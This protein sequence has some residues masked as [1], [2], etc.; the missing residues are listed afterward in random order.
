MISP[1][2]DVT[3][4]SDLPPLIGIVGPT[5]VGKSE[6]AVRLAD[7]LPVEIVSADSR[8]VYRGLDIGTAKPSPEERQRVP[9]H[10]IDL[11]DPEDDFSV[12]EFQD[13][14]YA[15]IDAILERGH[16]PLLVGGTGLYIRAV[17]EGVRFPRV[18]PDPALRQELEHRARQDGAAVLHRRLAQLDPLA[19]ARI[20]PRNIRRV[21]RALEVILTTGRR[22]S[23][24]EQPAPRYRSLLIGL[25][26]ARDELYHR[27]DTRVDAQ[28]ADGLVEET[29]QVLARGCP[30]D[31]PALQ[32]LGYRQIVAYLSG[33]MSLPAAI[34]RIKFE[35]HR[36]ARQQYTW[37]RLDDPEIHW[38]D[39][40]DP[41]T[42][43]RALQ[44]IQA[45]Q[46]IP[47]SREVAVTQ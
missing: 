30:P 14:A 36:F 25:T 4:N 23:D 10:L 19:A 11:V 3:R 34:E 1:S 22:F 15:A 33:R 24:R 35:T 18:E 29:R 21:I 32:G 40:A 47:T 9:H 41:A 42:F 28:I 27:I 26:R 5:A 43:E 44:L 45:F 12:V 17:V 7:V 31:R 39:A 20:D 37:F 8:Q 13:L 16:L 46:K 2:L 6:M 38:L